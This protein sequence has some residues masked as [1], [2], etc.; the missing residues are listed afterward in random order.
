MLIGNEMKLPVGWYFVKEGYVC[1]YGSNN[2]KGH[3]MN[4][5]LVKNCKV[6]WYEFW[7]WSK[8]VEMDWMRENIMIYFNVWIV[9]TKHA[10]LSLRRVINEDIFEV[11]DWNEDTHDSN[12]FEWKVK[13]TSACLSA[14]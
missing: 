11:S 12:S 1:V 9:V 6:V 13:L 3:I 14:W 10:L 2:D 5:S 4:R 7:L 8:I